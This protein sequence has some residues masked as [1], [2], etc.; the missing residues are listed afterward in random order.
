MTVVELPLF[1]RLARD[2]WDEA[3]RAASVDFIARSP[4]AGDVIP[5][6]GGVRKVRWRRAGIGKRGGVRV[7]YFYHDTRMPLFLI[8]VDAKARQGDLTPDEKKKVTA[9]ASLPRAFS[10]VNFH[11]MRA[12][13][14]LRCRCH[15]SISATSTPRSPMRRSRH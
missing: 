12:P 1:L 3:E 7:I 13:E 15:A 14:A 2:L 9:L 6:T 11:L 10:V 8:L 5:G 4:D